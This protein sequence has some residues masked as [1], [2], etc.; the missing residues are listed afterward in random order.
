M[1]KKTGNVS[2]IQ[3]ATP[4]IELVISKIANPTIKSP[5]NFS[6]TPRY[7]RNF[8]ANLR[9]GLMKNAATMN[10]NVKPIPNTNNNPTPLKAVS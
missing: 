1:F 2:I 4:L 10:G 6:T 8:P 7:L 3:L 9:K 5:I